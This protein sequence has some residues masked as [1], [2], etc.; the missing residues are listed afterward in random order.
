MCASLTCGDENAARR[1]TECPV[2]AALLSVPL[3]QNSHHFHLNPQK[4]ECNVW[5]GVKAWSGS[6]PFG[7]APGRHRKAGGRPQADQSLL[8][9][10]PNDGFRGPGSPALILNGF[11]ACL[12]GGTDA[13]KPL[14]SK[15]SDASTAARRLQRHRSRAGSGKASGA[16]LRAKATAP[17]RRCPPLHGAAA[18]R[19]AGDD[20]RRRT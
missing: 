5:S 7:R 8:G 17:W 11:P 19:D 4:T 18:C 1:G 9:R 15:G 13:A 10:R 12:A 6:A 2:P 14:D 16:R 3:G 20:V